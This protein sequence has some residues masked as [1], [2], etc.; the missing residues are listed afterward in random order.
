MKPSAMLY[1]A[2]LMVALGLAV[3]HLLAV[4]QYQ[5]G[6]LDEIAGDEEQA[7]AEY[8]TYQRLV[9]RRTVAV[10]GIVLLVASAAAA[11]RNI[12][13]GFVLFATGFGVAGLAATLE[14]VGLGYTLLRWPLFPMLGGQKPLVVAAAHCGVLVVVVLLYRSSFRQGKQGAHSGKGKSRCTT[15][16]P[17][18][19]PVH[20]PRPS[21]RTSRLTASHD[22]DE[23]IPD[24]EGG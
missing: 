7:L 11:G 19:T 16:R 21:L 2:L 1:R 13:E 20:Q 3:G 4:A 8:R 24:D 15:A 18:A 14:L 5:R 10:A 9:E 23:E 17:A 22:N 6:L 12:P